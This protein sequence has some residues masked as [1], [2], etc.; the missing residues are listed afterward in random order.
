MTSLADLERSYKTLLAAHAPVA[1][2]GQA[3]DAFEV[4]TLALVLRAAA[5]EGAAIGFEARSGISNPS[6]LKFRPAPGSVFAPSPDYS[7]AT[8]HFAPRL[9]FEAHIGIYV[10]GVAGVTHECDVAVIHASEGRFCRQTR[11]H[12]RRAKAILTAECKFYAG[13]LSIALGREFLGVTADLGVDG[14][15]FVSN[16]DSPTVD[17]ILA[18]HGRRRGLRLTPLDSDMETQVV[19]EFR[20]TFRDAKAKRR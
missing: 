11:V 15:F 17:R 5:E 13:R 4:Y 2:A 14:R 18:H 1:F 10:T 8:I 16:S 7:Y 9:D 6:P 20:S 19:G 12:P 3:N